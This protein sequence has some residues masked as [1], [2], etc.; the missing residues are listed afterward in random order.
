MF[1]FINSL[2]LLLLS[3]SSVAEQIQVPIYDQPRPPLALFIEEQPRGIYPDLFREILIQ[4][5]LEPILVPIPPMR[6]RIAFE[7]NQYS[8]SCCANPAW[9]KRPAEQE[10]QIFS[11]PFYWTKDIFVFP[12]GRA[13]SIDKLS[14][15]SDKRVATIRGYDYRGE[16]YFGERH[17]YHNEQA[18][19]RSVSLKRVEV[20]IVNE[21]I[22]SASKEL[23]HLEK[24]PVHDQASLHIRI[25]RKRIDLVEP[26]NKAIEEIIRSGKRDQIVQRYLKYEK[27][28][29][30]DH[31]R[32]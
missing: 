9:R 25:H 19:L 24:G 2:I 3:L 4:A 17:N 12:K 16:L 18:L 31:L 13:F 29:K 7:T 20:G 32:N 11:K 1:R 5:R 15:L 23:S 26:I 6:R 30:S 14:D 21:D 27:A 8:L 28:E 22:F 10:V